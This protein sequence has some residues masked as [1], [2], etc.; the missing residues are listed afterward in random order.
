[1]NVSIDM[2][3]SQHRSISKRFTGI[4]YG[5][6]IWHW[7]LPSA[8]A[9]QEQRR[10][11][12]HVLGDQHALFDDLPWLDVDSIK[13][14]PICLR[15]LDPSDVDHAARRVHVDERLTLEEGIGVGA[16]SIPVTKQIDATTYL[17]LTDA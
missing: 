9:Q 3:S 6:W 1:M 15:I 11:L 16:V 13:V 7:I 5:H 14:V 10:E 2:Y 8:H 17:E 4:G 12:P